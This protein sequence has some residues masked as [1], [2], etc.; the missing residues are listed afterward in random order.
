MFKK[1]IIFI[2]CIIGLKN[3]ISFID[4]YFGKTSQILIT[5]KNEKAHVRQNSIDPWIFV[6]NLIMD[7]Y[8][9]DSLKAMSFSNIIDIGSNVGLFSIRAHILWPQAKLTCVEPNPES[10]V[11]LK[12]NLKL[13]NIKAV[14][15][16]KAMTDNSQNKTTKLFL[17]E[18]SAMSSV[19]SGKGK[20]VEVK[21]INMSDVVYNR[22]TKSLMKMDI[23]GG[24][25]GLISKNNKKLFKLIDIILMETHDLNKKENHNTVIEYLTKLGFVV[26]KNDRNIIAVNSQ[27]IGK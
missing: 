3:P 9:L 10:I 23:E 16:E 18:N 20:Y 13:N 19:K 1:I 25:Y 26:S 17:N 27:K 2:K 7:T 5:N 14:I 8:R 12:K 15:V 21:T 11:E 24:E 6:E 4:A 22:S